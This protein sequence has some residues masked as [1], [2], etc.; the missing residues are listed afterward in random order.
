MCFTAKPTWEWTVSIFHV[1]V[2]IAGAVAVVISMLLSG[3]TDY[4]PLR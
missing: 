2:A 4:S 1:P 3:G